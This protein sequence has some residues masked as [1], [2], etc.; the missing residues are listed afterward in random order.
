MRYTFYGGAR[1]LTDKA[2]FKLLEV[3]QSVSELASNAMTQP[4]CHTL[5]VWV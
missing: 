3:S 1:T 5:A 4:V 2:T